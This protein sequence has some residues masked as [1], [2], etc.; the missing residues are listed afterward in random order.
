MAL[1][2]LADE[3]FPEREGFGVWI[4][5][6]EDVHVLLDPEKHYRQQLLPQ[7]APGRGLEVEGNYVL[8]LLGRVLCELDRTVGAVAEPLRVFA[9]IRMVR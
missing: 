3:P 4:V 8:V 1:L 7:L 5:H 9:N 6:T 2:D